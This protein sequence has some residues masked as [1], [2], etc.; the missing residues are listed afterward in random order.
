[1]PNTLGL[2]GAGHEILVKIRDIFKILRLFCIATPRK[3][4]HITITNTTRRRGPS[5]AFLS[6]DFVGPKSAR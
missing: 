6:G 4:K 2:Y 5:F 1:M 3:T